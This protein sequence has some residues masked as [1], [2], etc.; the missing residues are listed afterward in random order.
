LASNRDPPDL[1]LLSSW[2][3][4]CEPLVPGR[5]VTLLV[6]AWLGQTGSPDRLSDEHRLLKISEK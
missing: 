5:K 4:R 6:A 1:C 2:D 3:Y